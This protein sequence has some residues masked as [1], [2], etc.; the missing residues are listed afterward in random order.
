MPFT[1]SARFNASSF[2]IFKRSLMQSDELPLA[3]IMDG[4]IIEQ[5]F[6][7]YESIKWVRRNS[8]RHGNSCMA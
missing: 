1:S 7:E 3:D 8:V 5:V 4:T 6:E 2:S